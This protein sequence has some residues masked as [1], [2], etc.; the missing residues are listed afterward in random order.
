T[1]DFP[2]AS[3]GT[4]TF[5]ANTWTET[6][7]DASTDDHPPLKQVTVNW[8]DGTVIF[9]DTTAPFGPAVHT[10][11]NPGSFT[12]THKAIDSIG[13]EGTQLCA[14]TPAFFTISGTVNTPGG[15]GNPLPG[16]VVTAKKGTTT[17][18]VAYSAQNG[19]FSIGNLKP[20]TYTLTVTR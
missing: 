15:P 14:A 12:V 1:P 5:D 19:S 3:A 11:L 18:G 7:T 17:V 13:Q 4:C 10:Y 2:P 20:G 16:A 8:G 9:N 6:V